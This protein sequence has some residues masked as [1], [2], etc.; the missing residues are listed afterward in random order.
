MS[1][2]TFWQNIGAALWVNF[3]GRN[4]TSS[5]Y[6]RADEQG[7]MIMKNNKGEQKIPKD[8]FDEMINKK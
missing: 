1:K 6:I 2:T 4:D 5:F 3:T 8:K 7:N